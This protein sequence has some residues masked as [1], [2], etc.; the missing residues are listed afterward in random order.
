MQLDEALRSKF[1][2]SYVKD[3]ISLILK[4]QEAMAI[5][6]VRDQHSICS[7]TKH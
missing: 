3:D 2:A 7:S 5:V 4:S 6:A 1:N